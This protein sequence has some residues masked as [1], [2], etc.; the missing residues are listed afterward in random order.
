MREYM[1]NSIKKTLREKKE[2]FLFNSIPVVIVNSLPKH[3]N[4]GIVLDMIEKNI[5]PHLLTNIEG[6]YF[7]DFEELKK[8]KIKSMFKD[9][10]IYISSYKEEEET[11][12]E[13]L[14]AQDIIHEIAH[15]VEEKYNYELYGDNLIEEEFLNKRNKL[16]K[17]MQSE[18]FEVAQI[19]D[20]M[21]PD[22]KVSF[23]KFLFNIV[24]YNKL[25]IMT[26]GLFLNPYSVTSLREYFASAFEE[27]Y[28]GDRKYLKHISNVLYNKIN[29]LG[30]IDDQ[31]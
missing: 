8:R 15:A 18:G 30:E 7:G 4:L 3:I 1:K 20:F 10:V 16:Y 23:D 6:F 14:I 12:S 11:I 21:E 31:S 19:E 2:W 5:P 25:S 29:E 26:L 9:G 17:I 27:Y 22:Y 24:G 13:M 28:S